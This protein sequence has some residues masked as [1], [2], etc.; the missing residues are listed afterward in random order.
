MIKG[1]VITLGVPGGIAVYK[2]ADLA[3]KLTG[4]GAT[5]N[6]IMTGSA[7]EFVKPVTFQVLTKNPVHTDLFSSS[8]E[9][10][11]PHI[12]LAASADLFLIAPATANIIGKIAAGIGDDLL[13]TSVLAANCPVL[14]C[15]AMNVKMYSNPIVQ[16]NIS[17]LKE[18]D[19]HFVEPEQ[20]LVA[21][22]DYGKGR[23]SDS[24][25][26]IYAIEQL[27]GQAKDM[28]GL[29][30]LITAGGTREAIDPVRYISNRSSG[31]MG[32]ALA[33][34]VNSRGG[35]AIL[36]STPT[37]L[38]IP[39]GVEGIIVESAMEMRDAVLK[40]YPHCQIIIKAAAVADYRCESVFS[41]KLKKDGESLTLKLIKNPDILA[42]LG[43][44]KREDQ[45]LV[46]FAAETQF[47]DQNAKKKLI[48]KK[49]DLLVANDV[50]IPGSGFG[51]DSNRVKLF[52]S[53]GMVEELPLLSKLIV[54]NKIIDAVKN[55]RSKR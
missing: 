37:C 19:F 1:K 10:K 30:V 44:S 46:G 35:Q 54:A 28:S 16:A 17:K 47:L 40:H 3:S 50:S 39:L 51:S 45:T 38:E 9:H 27:L 52:Y 14:I 4:L 32:Y 55:I 23:L 2:V 20:G 11:I 7:T 41:E 12:E 42:E 25:T 15:P 5:V 49:L 24:S 29:R 31:K 21:C 26:I 53:D 48:S 13:S 36:I 22:G 43:C 33:Q 6:T 18:Y 8:A 34:A